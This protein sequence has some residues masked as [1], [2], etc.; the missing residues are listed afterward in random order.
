M[1]SIWSWAEEFRI[2]ATHTD[3]GFRA[4]VR[5]KI[6]PT[7]DNI[8][9][10]ANLIEAAQL[11]HLRRRTEHT[12]LP[13]E[14]EAVLEAQAYEYVME[15]ARQTVVNGLVVVLWHLF[16][17]RLLAFSRQALL[18]K[19]ERANVAIFRIQ[20]L[21][22]RLKRE[23]GIDLDTFRFWSKLSELKYLANALKHGQGKS[24]NALRKLRPDFFRLSPHAEKLLK[25]LQT[26][27]GVAVPNPPPREVAS[28]LS[29][30]E[31]RVESKDLD[32]YFDAVISFWKEL[33]TEL[34]TLGQH[35]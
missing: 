19:D 4:A 24:C 31:I 27:F 2:L 20:E 14:E 29:D 15:S 17:Q 8:S 12:E 35:H 18:D 10:E 33:A 1:S 13:P 28:P 7:F 23:Y 25:T 3:E 34:E 30:H 5:D 32:G 21:R 26:V 6:L 22:K 9:S 16:E 11:E